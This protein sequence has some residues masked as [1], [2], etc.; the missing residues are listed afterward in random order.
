MFWLVNR[1]LTVLLLQWF[2]REN[3]E[4]VRRD[5]RGV[6]RSQQRTALV[7]SLFSGTHSKGSSSGRGGND[8]VKQP[9]A[10]LS[11]STVDV[12]SAAPTL[13]KSLGITLSWTNASLDR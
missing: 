12:S 5:C 7:L 3:E 4:S 11:L 6:R 10:L 8:L 1:S 13:G 9:Q 2:A